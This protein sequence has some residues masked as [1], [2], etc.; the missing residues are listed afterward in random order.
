MATSAMKVEEVN[1]VCVCVCAH[2]LCACGH[3]VCRIWSCANGNSILVFGCHVDSICCL[4]FLLRLCAVSPVCVFLQQ[5][6]VIILYRNGIWCSNML[7]LISRQFLKTLRE[8]LH[9][10]LPE[11]QDTVSRSAAGFWNI[12]HAD[13]ADLS[14]ACWLAFGA[15]RS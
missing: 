7:V 6:S 3:I 2:M 13:S 12:S 10:P 14:D 15:V 11:G 8:T 1:T 9:S 5:C 4:R